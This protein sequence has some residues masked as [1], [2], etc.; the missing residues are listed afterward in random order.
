MES[1]ANSA[2]RSPPIP[3]K[4]STGG[5]SCFLSSWRLQFAVTSKSI[6]IWIQLF[7]VIFYYWSFAQW[8]FSVK[9]EG[10]KSEKQGAYFWALAFGKAALFCLYIFSPICTTWP[11]K[12]HPPSPGKYRQ[13]NSVQS[14]N[15]YWATQGAQ[16]LTLGNGDKQKRLPTL[17]C[18]GRRIFPS[19][20][21]G[22]EVQVPRP[23]DSWFSHPS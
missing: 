1:T 8:W 18:W 6:S 22:P 3:R 12:H 21:G 5:W 16:S 13:P 23:H 19:G 10:N 4:Q 2:H 15:G 17:G 14:V 9:V 11:E 20:G 7:S